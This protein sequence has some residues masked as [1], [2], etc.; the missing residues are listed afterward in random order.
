VAGEPV[1]VGALLASGEIDA[2]KG[3]AKLT[4]RLEAALSKLVKES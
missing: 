2:K 3:A 4:R 1:D